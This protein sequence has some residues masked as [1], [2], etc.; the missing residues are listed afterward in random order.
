M[1]YLSLHQ[2]SVGADMVICFVCFE[3]NK[4]T[5]LCFAEAGQFYAKHLPPVC[6]STD[7]CLHLQIL[8]QFHE[9]ANPAKLIAL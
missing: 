4:K 7:I 5:R 9:T 3:Y 1:K 6:R 2:I 8:F